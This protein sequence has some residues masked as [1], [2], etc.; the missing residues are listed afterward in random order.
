MEDA[1]VAP[2]ERTYIALMRLLE[3]DTHL[4]TQAIAITKKALEAFQK[5]DVI[6]QGA[7]SCMAMQ[8]VKQEVRETAR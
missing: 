5:S 2:D 1:G 4:R 8:R 3:R 7:I 6:L